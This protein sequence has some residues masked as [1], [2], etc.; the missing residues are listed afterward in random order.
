MTPLTSKM[1]EN[2]PAPT[3]LERVPTV[4]P[5]R[6]LAMAVKWLLGWEDDVRIKAVSVVDEA[7]NFQHMFTFCE[8]ATSEVLLRHGTQLLDILGEALEQVRR[9]EVRGRYLRVLAR[10]RP[11]T[12]FL[13]WCR[14]RV[15]S[16]LESLDEGH[17][18]NES[19]VNVRV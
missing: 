4:P 8:T 2:Y 19:S 11:S 16:S 3:I 5:P 15:R 6:N 10:I 1:K 7:S 9:V 18:S 14:M 17:T 13:D 12:I